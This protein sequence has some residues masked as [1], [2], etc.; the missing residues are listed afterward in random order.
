MTISSPTTWA[1][2]DVD[3]ANGS[4]LG[5]ERKVDMLD[6]LEIKIGIVALFL[7]ALL[8][9]G[10]SELEPTEPEVPEYEP[11]PLSLEIT[12]GPTADSPVPYGSVVTLRWK[13]SGG[14]GSYLYSYRLGTE[15]DFSPWSS[16]TSVSYAT[17]DIGPGDHNFYVKVKTDKDPETQ[18][19]EHAFKVSEPE[20]TPPEVE[21]TYPWA[22]YKAATGSDI[23]VNW[24][25]TP[26]S[27][28]LGIAGTA[29]AVDDTA[30]WTFDPGTPMS[31]V[32]TGF[33][34]GTHTI[35]VGA[36]DLN[37]NVGIAT[38]QVE[39][40][41]PTILYIDEEVLD[42][43]Y[44]KDTAH[45]T[46]GGELMHD[47]FYEKFV[48]DGFAYEEWDIAEKGYPEM[49]QIPSS[50]TTI[51]WVGS[52]D[53]QNSSWGWNIGWEYTWSIYD[54]TYSPRPAPNFFTEAQDAGINI[55]L[56]GENFLEEVDIGFGGY[57]LPEG[58]EDVYLHL[59]AD[60]TYGGTVALDVSP[61][62]NVVG[63]YP[64]MSVDNAKWGHAIGDGG[65]PEWDVDV[66]P[67]DEDAE[68]IYQNEE[69]E[70]IGIRWPA[71]GTD[72]KFVFTAFPLYYFPGG[73]VSTLA[74]QILGTEFGN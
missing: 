12:G 3:R 34:D 4:D 56:I 36:K 6:R 23:L 24:T 72:T 16:S 21:I 63:V 71:G 49:D 32:L 62:D 64:A 11:S 14:K 20:T 57:I 38:V 47:S 65:G 73:A 46:P 25:V 45:L 54:T 2:S 43:G 22:G 7:G 69:G 10:C 67:P 1:S 44:S 13:A 8:W 17:V 42:A 26:K 37:G 18:P 9:S 29:V 52:G 15:G 39:I 5:R 50:I 48:F 58:F 27:Q 41:P 61:T 19:I 74:K 55:W 28:P 53:Y 31:K 40:M 30:G 68:P 66:L 60:S 59:I 33:S 70:V 51:V 35:Y